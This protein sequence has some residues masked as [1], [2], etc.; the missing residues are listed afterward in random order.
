MA[1]VNK[2]HKFYHI[3][4]TKQENCPLSWQTKNVKFLFEN[5][6]HWSFYKP[7][8]KQHGCVSV[9]GRENLHILNDS[10]SAELLIQVYAA[11]FSRKGLD[12]ISKAMPNQILHIL[13]QCGSIHRLRVK[14]LVHRFIKIW[15][16]GMWNDK[17][18][19]SYINQEQQNILLLKLK[20]LFQQLTVWKN[21]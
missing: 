18:Q 4:N 3:S 15:Q 12:Y 8:F 9:H 16:R 5:K 19:K 17:K 10:V 21:S 6:S 14:S 1:N 7:K 20:Q 13:E 2:I 11:I